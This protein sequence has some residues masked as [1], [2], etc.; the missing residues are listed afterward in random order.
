MTTGCVPSWASWSLWI[1]QM[2]FAG[3]GIVALVFFVFINARAHRQM[4][5][6]AAR[7]AA[8]EV[9]MRRAV[10][11]AARDVLGRRDGDG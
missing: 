6:S 3:V 10:Q 1:L 5:E 8:L 11:A 2:A 7:S 4:R 9:E